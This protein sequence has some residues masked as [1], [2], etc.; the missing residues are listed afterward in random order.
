MNRP[1]PVQV[2]Q[3]DEVTAGWLKDLDAHKPEIPRISRGPD[4]SLVA[5]SHRARNRAR[6]VTGEACA[7]GTC[8]VRRLADG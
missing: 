6:L 7:L 3:A 2:V 1:R 8:G 5:G 4:Q